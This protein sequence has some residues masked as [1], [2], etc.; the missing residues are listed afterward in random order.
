VRKWWQRPAQTLAAALLLSPVTLHAASEGQNVTIRA[1]SG[2]ADEIIKYVAEVSELDH[3]KI[4]PNETVDAFITKRCGANTNVFKDLFLE[5]NKEALAKAP[6][7]SERSV[8]MPACI[9]WRNFR[10]DE[11]ET[12]FG[13][14]AVKIVVGDSLEAVLQRRIGFGPDDKLTCSPT[15]Q[16]RSRCNRTYRDLV[17][18]YN[19]GRIL[20][21]LDPRKELVL[22][23][24]TEPRTVRLNRDKVAQ[25]LTAAQVVAK[26]T[27]LA[28]QTGTSAAIVRNVVA[29][30][31]RLLG[32]VSTEDLDPDR[33][34][35]RE[36]NIVARRPWPYNV[37]EVAEAITRSLVAAE[38]AGGRRNNHVVT[39][40]VDTGLDPKT[41]P[42]RFLKK[43]T[44]ANSKPGFGIGIDQEGVIAPFPKYEAQWHGTQVAHIF[45]GGSGLRDA[46]PGLSAL[47]KLNVVNLVETK[48]QSGG[49][50]AYNISAA[51][52]GR[53][54]SHAIETAQVA[55]MS[56]GSATQLTF[57]EQVLRQKDLLLVVAAGNERNKFGASD[58]PLYPAKYGGTGQAGM[59]V[60]TVAAHDAADE[61][62]EF[63]NWNPAYV[64]IAAP[65]CAV[66]YTT[67][68][69][70]ELL[71]GTSFAA[72]LVSLTTALIMVFDVPPADVKARLQASS[73]FVPTL[74]NK[75]T[76][77]GRL[78]IAKSVA[79]YDDVLETRSSPELKYFDWNPGDNY[80][81]L[82]AD[83]PG[84]SPA[85]IRKITS[86]SDKPPYSIRLL[87]LNEGMLEPKPCIAAGEGLPH[88]DADGT[89]KDIPWSDLVDLVPRYH[90]IQ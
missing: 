69:G 49:G 7:T 6:L 44:I 41:F 71:Y 51:G 14:V 45:T 61:I 73:D 86:L 35:C 78:N 36:A 1:T 56:V 11:S 22:P 77:S 88:V 64:D 43:N 80:V 82:C 57:A 30:D 37:K 62:A 63:S 66:P 68:A 20:E 17:Q 58:P 10:R 5:L 90:R 75:V 81:E 65:G 31:V 76:W 60:I 8:K 39:T 13:G 85:K 24:V 42:E 46:F 40:I 47:I 87:L 89:R 19:R 53:G 32:A 54:L 29:P 67:E 21:P 28:Q 3:L 12:Q 55:N 70:A 72:P 34:E 52:V 9:M 23:L 38:R 27:E 26:I 50:E 4:P 2:V 84:H 74:A 79:L 59:R 15:A 83:E 16:Q 33:K 25:G 48:N 18:Q